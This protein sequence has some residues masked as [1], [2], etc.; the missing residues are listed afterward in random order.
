M[1]KLQEYIKYIVEKIYWVTSEINK[2]QKSQSTGNMKETVIYRNI[3]EEKTFVYMR[4]NK[5]TAL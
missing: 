4:A 3:N 5:M 1:L 2:V